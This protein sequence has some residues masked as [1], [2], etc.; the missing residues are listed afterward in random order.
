LAIVEVAK[1]NDLSRTY[2]TRTHLGYILNPGDH[3][4]GYDLTL[5]NFNDENWEYLNIGRAQGIIPDVVLVRKSYPHARKKSKKRNWRLK[6]I[7]KEAELESSKTKM[8]KSKAE[9]DYETFLRD[10]EEDPELRAMMNL[11]KAPVP[12]KKPVSKPADDHE[13]DDGDEASET[14][15]P[16]IDVSDLLEDFDDLALAED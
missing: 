4:L 14:D 1:T 9:Q 16:Q 8:E 7:A 10:I 11:Y 3:V 5:S 15:F 6:N 2:I 12:E 13:M